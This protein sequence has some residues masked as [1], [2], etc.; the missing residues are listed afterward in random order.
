[1]AENQQP[2][3]F[4]LITGEGKLHDEGYTL[5]IV[6]RKNGLRRMV[7]TGF[8]AFPHQWDV[9]NENF[10]T[11]NRV[12]DLHPQRKEANE[13]LV[14]KKKELKDLL[15]RFRTQNIDWTVEQFVDAFL[16]STKAENVY[17][18]FQSWINT[19]E[20]K[21][22]FSSRQ[23]FWT[24]HTLSKFDPK[25][26][27]RVWS[28]IDYSY[29]KRF[30][31]KLE[32]EG[33][34]GKGCA[35]NTRVYYL[36]GLRNMYNRAIKDK[37]AAKTVYPFGKDGGFSIAALEEDT[38]KRY[39]KSKDLEKVKTEVA[40]NEYREKVRKI[41]MF[42]YY[43]YGMSIRD[44]ALLK[45]N[46]IW[47]LEDGDYIVYKRNK[48]KHNRKSKPIYIKINDNIRELLEWFKEKTTLVGNYLV[49]VVSIDYEAESVKL[50]KHITYRNRR[51]NELLKGIAQ[52]LAINMKIT[53]HVNRHTAA[54]RLQTMSIS[55]DI[56]QEMLGHTD[57]KTTETYL[58]S[59]EH[60]VV[61]EAGSVL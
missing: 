48:T 50:D 33:N 8:F 12:K 40:T 10:V 29:V 9:I 36:K 43:C 3:H 14:I 21:H 15:E 23:F 51:I 49:P 41:F 39:I 1:M 24:C 27:K 26:L 37:C 2:Y 47:A 11:D 17:D 22:Y 45:K 61:A 28:E 31:S 20:S 16:Y 46:N 58:D 60:N 52:D 32:T 30:D 38:P 44:A 57:A 13:W 55:R 5:N 7:S 6:I 54:M 19:L 18:Y 25:F 53:T 56:I 59:F 35:G 4:K 34:K 42:C